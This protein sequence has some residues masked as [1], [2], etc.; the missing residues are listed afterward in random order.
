MR[1]IVASSFGTA[2]AN[3]AT[4]RPRVNPRSEWH[5]IEAPHL[6]IVPQELREETTARLAK[7]RNAN[8]GRACHFVALCRPSCAVAR[9]TKHR[10]G[11]LV[12]RA[13]DGPVLPFDRVEGLRV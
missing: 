12:A 13:A 3:S 9:A 4:R 6:R 10:L 1:S 5:R 8:C 2:S 11:R 7:A